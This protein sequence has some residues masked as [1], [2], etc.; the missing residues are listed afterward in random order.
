MVCS[1]HKYIVLYYYDKCSDGVAV[2]GYV[3]HQRNGYYSTEKF[4]E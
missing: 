3:E 2:K 4:G 1:T